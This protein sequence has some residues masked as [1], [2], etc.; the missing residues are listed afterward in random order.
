MAK[1]FSEAETAKFLR[2]LRVT[3]QTALAQYALQRGREAARPTA[4]FMALAAKGV[5]DW[6]F[7][8]A[9]LMSADGL[10]LAKLTHETTGAPI[11]EVQAQGLV[12]LS[13]YASRAARVVFSGAREAQGVFDRDGRMRLLLEE[14]TI[15]EQDLATFELQLLDEAP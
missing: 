15:K 13:L 10:A 4:T 2:T 5:G 14:T 6:R 8:A 9:G 11:L 12:G 3:T 7:P 1:Q